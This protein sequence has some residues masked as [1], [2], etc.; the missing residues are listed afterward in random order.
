MPA[1]QPITQS[2]SL[3]K[4]K[5]FPVGRLGAHIKH[6][7]GASAFDYWQDRARCCQPGSC[8]AGCNTGKAS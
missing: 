5:G 7:I 6:G 1:T 4:K 3:V 8:G 2:K